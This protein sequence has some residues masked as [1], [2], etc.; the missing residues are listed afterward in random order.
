MSLSQNTYKWSYVN[1]TEELSN[2]EWK[3]EALWETYIEVE[4]RGARE[5]EFF[6]VL[7]SL[8]PHQPS[9]VAH[10]SGEHFQQLSCAFFYAEREHVIHNL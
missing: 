7:F 9:L 5:T 1:G 6:L 3:L 2:L 10:P 8:M 4:R